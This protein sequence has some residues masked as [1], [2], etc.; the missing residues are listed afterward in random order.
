M[1]ISMMKV[2]V[3]NKARVWYEYQANILSFVDLR[4]Q[5]KR[6][7]NVFQSLNL[8]FNR[9]I[10]VSI[11]ILTVAFFYTCMKTKFVKSG[12]IIQHET[13]SHPCCH[14]SPYFCGIML[15]RLWKHLRRKKLIVPG[16]MGLFSLL[17]AKFF[18]LRPCHIRPSQHIKQKPCRKFQPVVF[19]L[20]YLYLR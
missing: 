19:H 11:V 17:S 6:F 16:L 4:W 2:H 14:Y 7:I 3:S 10:F 13:T 9:A 12:K 15:A 1:V 18:T 5:E 20:A 8:I